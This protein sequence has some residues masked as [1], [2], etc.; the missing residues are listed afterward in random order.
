MLRE[1][2]QQNLSHSHYI[3]TL[4]PPSFATV[5]CMPASYFDRVRSSFRFAHG[6][7]NVGTMR[8]LE[9]LKEMLCDDDGTNGEVEE[10]EQRDV[11]QHL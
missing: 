3:E 2:E 11:V 5:S 9:R 8:K 6:F 10:R 4:L 1:L 7:R